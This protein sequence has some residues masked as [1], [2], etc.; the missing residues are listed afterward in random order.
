MGIGLSMDAFSVSI[1]DG[2]NEIKM[3]LKKM[4]LIAFSFAFFQAFMPFVGWIC[5]HHFAK[6]FTMFDNFIPWISLILL[7]FI[8][9]KMI[10]EGVRGNE[11]NEVKQLTPKV[12]FIQSI[13][14]SLDA[15]SVGFTIADYNITLALFACLIISAVTFVI[16]LFGVKLGKK[17]GGKLTDKAMIFGGVILVFIGIEILIRSFF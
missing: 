15:L 13:A 4:L 1:A 7:G 3:S 10:I 2:L 8:G 16:C 12:L 9:G 11:E 17:V 14:T 6:Q 5:V